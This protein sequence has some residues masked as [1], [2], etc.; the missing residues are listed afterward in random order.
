MENGT[1]G[2]PI[3]GNTD[4]P[5]ANVDAPATSANVLAGIENT[6]ATILEIA[7]APKVGGTDVVNFGSSFTNTIVK[8][9]IPYVLAPRGLVKAMNLP[10]VLK[11][12]I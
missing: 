7:T 3:F 6:L 8:A 2:N 11:C 1:L 10:A 5:P 4:H 9:A 12:I